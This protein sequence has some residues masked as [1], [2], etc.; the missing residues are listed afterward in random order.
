MSLVKEH[1]D[2]RAE[3]KMD[4]KRSKL[5]KADWQV[6][7]CSIKSN[8]NCRVLGT[9]WLELPI[10]TTAWELGTT[11]ACLHSCDFP[12]PQNNQ[13]GDCARVASS[14]AAFLQSR[15]CLLFMSRTG[16]ESS[17]LLFPQMFSQKCQFQLVTFALITQPCPSHKEL[18]SSLQGPSQS[19][20]ISCV[21]QTTTDFSCVS[22]QAWRI[23]HAAWH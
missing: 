23:L 8:Y 20:R 9:L 14:P 1:Q 3:G 12:P 15:N 2:E 6:T 16:Y 18:L 21:P 22:N 4:M 7:W 11:S 13:S 5:A 17:P 10:M 19:S